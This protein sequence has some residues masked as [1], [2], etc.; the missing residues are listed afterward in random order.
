MSR[1]ERSALLPYSSRALFEL[2]N[3]IEQYPQYLKGCVGAQV[4]E[5]GEEDMLARLD[6][7]R[8]GVRFSLTTRNR[9]WPY[10]R[11]ELTLVDGPFRALRGEWSFEALSE[12]S[13]RVS[14]TLEFELANRLL[15]AA[16]ARALRGVATDMVDAMVR[17]ARQVYG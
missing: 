12:Q 1:I 5:R 16:A 4:L 3:D 11:I 6:L 2:V 7:S 8:A 15:G 14:L 17:R 10:E 9:L 13:C